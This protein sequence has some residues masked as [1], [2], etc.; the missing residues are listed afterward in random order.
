MAKEQIETSGGRLTTLLPQR[1]GGFWVLL[2]LA[3]PR[4]AGA[5]FTI[6]LRRFIGPR[7]AGLFDTAMVPYRFLDSFRSYGTGPALIYELEIDRDTAN[8]AWTVNMLFAVG[9]TVLAQLV[10]HPVALYYHRP[11]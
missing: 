6:A 5:F 8:T 2:A 10:A 11:A 1:E 7:G 9:V 3:M 4:V